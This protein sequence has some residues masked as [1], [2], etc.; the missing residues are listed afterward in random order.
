[1]KRSLAI[2]LALSLCLSACA[3]AATETAGEAPAAATAEA[4]PAAEASAPAAIV[5][6]LRSFSASLNIG[7][8]CY[9]METRQE[10]DGSYHG[11]VTRLNYTDAEQTEVCDMGTVEQ[12]G[13]YFLWQDKICYVTWPSRQEAVVHLRS[14]ADGTEETF[15]LETEFYP[16]YLDDQYLYFCRYDPFLQLERMDLA[17]GE[18]QSLEIPSMTSAICDIDGQRLLISRLISDLPLETLWDDSEQYDAALQN[19]TV[20]YAW[21]DPASG[22]VETVLEEPAKGERDENGNDITR[23]YIGRDEGTLFFYRTVDTEGTTTANHI[24]RCAFDGSGSEVFFDPGED[25]VSPGA[26]NVDGEIRWLLLS[27]RDS[28]LVFDLAAGQQ[29][30]LP[31]DAPWPMELTSDGRVLI[32]VQP[33]DSES[34]FRYRLVDQQDYLAGNFNGTDVDSVWL[35]TAK[36]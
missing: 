15:S 30:T 3:P 18:V 1:M 22:T 5:G 20:Q 34:Q 13:G 36:E 28:L 8:A 19:A 17:T 4:A 24:E 2:L 27:K 35:E 10:P 26:V 21:W 31:S 33:K 9:Q 32:S 14:L 12:L 6:R 25:I 16:N 7:D 23:I 11:I 29:Y